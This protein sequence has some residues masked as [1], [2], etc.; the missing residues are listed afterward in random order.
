MTTTKLSFVLVSLFVMT[1]HCLPVDSLE[2]LVPTKFDPDLVEN[3]RLHWYLPSCNVSVLFDG[4]N[5]PPSAS[6]TAT[7]WLN[8]YGRNLA[9]PNRSQIEQATALIDCLHSKH[10]DVNFELFNCFADLLIEDRLG[11][12]KYQFTTTTT[13]STTTT[14]ESTTTTTTVEPTTT[15]TTTAEPTTTNYQPKPSSV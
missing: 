4:Y 6:K 15:T 3:C 1:A 7:L 14:G 12:F 2:P 8:E 5:L 13:T 10:L 11:R 9:F